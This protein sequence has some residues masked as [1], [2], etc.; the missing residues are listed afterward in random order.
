LAR[1][2]EAFETWAFFSLFLVAT[3]QFGRILQKIGFSK[4]LFFV[5]P[6]FSLFFLLNFGFEKPKIFLFFSFFQFLSRLNCRKPQ[7]Y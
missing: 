5:F 3:F 1:F 4:P 2:D 7:S 6:F